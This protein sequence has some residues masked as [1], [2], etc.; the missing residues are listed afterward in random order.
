M[1]I[2]L[3][4][5]LEAK[6]SLETVRRVTQRLNE[7]MTHRVNSGL[8]F[9]NPL[10]GIRAVFKKP[11][12]ENM[13]AL[14]PEELPELITGRITSSADDRS[15]SG[16]VSTFRKRQRA[17]SRPARSKWRGIAWCQPGSAAA[18]VPQRARR[19]A[20]WRQWPTHLALC[21]SGSLPG[22][23][24]DAIFTPWRPSKM[25]GCA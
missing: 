9:A 17:M 13:A 21:L 5:P 18:T 15:W 3:L 8:I 24:A 19:Q 22:A 6:G 16:R 12:K 7:I 20:H 11:K 1:V 10:S 14:P 23:A 4:R 2:E 25:T